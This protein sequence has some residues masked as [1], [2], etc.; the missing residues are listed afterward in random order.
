[1]IVKL[2]LAKTDLRNLE[3]TQKFVK[4]Y[5]SDHIQLLQKMEMAIE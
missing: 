2:L 4:A 5:K 1:M 3:D